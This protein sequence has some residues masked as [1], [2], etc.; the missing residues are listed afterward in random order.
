MVNCRPMVIVGI[1]PVSAGYS[2]IAGALCLAGLVNPV[3][4]GVFPM[5]MRL[6]LRGQR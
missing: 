5:D 3:H 6:V 2:R 1:V 4:A